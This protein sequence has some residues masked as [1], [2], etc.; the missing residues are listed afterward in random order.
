MIEGIETLFQQIADSMID[1]IP[2]SWSEA[3]F[4]AIFYPDSST[5]EAEYVRRSDGRARSFQPTSSGSRA[6]RQIRAL[7][8]Q[9]GKPVWGQACFELRVDGTFGMT[10]GYENCDGD[11]NT[12]FDEVE[13]LRRHEERHRRLT[14]D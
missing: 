8:Q 11:G 3:R 13:E 4:E 5:Y 10:W 14:A 2:D 12:R 7:F 9:A 1:A 6:F